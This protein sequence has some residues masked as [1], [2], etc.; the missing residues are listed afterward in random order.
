MNNCGVYK[1]T[2]V[3]TGD[4][5]IGSSAYL[6]KR[7]VN[8]QYHLDKNC[9]VN[10][11]LQRSWNKYGN[12]S[13]EFSVCEH[14]EKEL[15]IEREQFYI[16]SEKPTYNILPKAGSSLGVKRSEETKQRLSEAHI[17]FLPTE[18]SNRKRS[19]TLKGK[20]NGKLGTHAS[21]ET[22]RKMSDSHKHVS[23]ES[24]RKM[25]ESHKGELNHMFGK[26]LSEE[27]RRKI[28][29]AHKTIQMVKG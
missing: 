28:S 7:F 12:Q 3:V 2:N 29:E 13:F 9:H 15:L 24:K 20:P 17:G 11:H 26:H 21:D 10:I 18:E 22:K 23:D 25:S 6:H 4:F 1:I 14:C 27:H 8:H 19:M 16:D 5:Y